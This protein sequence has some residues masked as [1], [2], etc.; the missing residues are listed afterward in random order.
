ADAGGAGFDVVWHAGLRDAV[1]SVIEQAAHGGSTTVDLGPLRD[2]L[3]TPSGFDFPWRAV[4]M[5][6]N[7]DVLLT[8][9]SDEDRKPRIAAMA[10]PS[11]R[12]SWFAGSRLRVANGLLVSGPG[13]P[14]LFLGQ[15][16]LED[17]LWNDSPDDPDHRIWW[18]GLSR[19]RAMSDHLRFTRELIAL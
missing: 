6:E 8:S 18:D 15:E 11:N 19:D 13:V 17:K 7:H 16:F 14:M 2:A 4:Q 3:A 1:R 10:D 5:L 9:H 12:R